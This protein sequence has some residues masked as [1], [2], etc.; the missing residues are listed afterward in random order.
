M[1]QDLPNVTTGIGYTNTDAT[2]LLVCRLLKAMTA[3]GV[4][5]AAPRVE[6]TKAMKSVPA[7]SLSSTYIVRGAKEPP[8]TGDTVP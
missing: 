5:F 1:L 7:L 2:A 3:K 4:A 6:D 8:K